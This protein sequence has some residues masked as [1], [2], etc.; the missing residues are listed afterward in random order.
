[1]AN[2]Q[3]ML[4][5][6]PRAVGRL[7]KAG[8][9][10]PSRGARNDYLFSFQ[11]IVLLRS[12]QALQAANVPPRRLLR[13]LRLLR[14]ALPGE[15]PLSGLRVK[16]IGDR[17]AVKEAGSHWDVE[18][19]QVLMDFEVATA[20][21]AVA[22]IVAATR[23][24]PDVSP[25]PVSAD[26]W[27]AQAESLEPSDPAAAMRAYRRALEIQPG[28]AGALTNLGALLCEAGDSQEALTLYE[29]AAEVAPDEP[30][31]HFNGAIALEDLGLHRAALRAYAHCLMLA[32]YMGDAH[33]NAARLCEQLGDQPGA[34]R[35]FNALRRMHKADGSEL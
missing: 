4:G 28:H 9:I 29:R 16:A 23:N 13:S 21:G 2:V 12:V 18:S 26:D 34:L 22:F 7:V 3:S 24:A 8:Y 15:L 25:D 35:H 10:A 6:T 17:V 27:V 32:P 33:Y 1:M 5:L 20:D 31:I 11:D 19:G 30:L 14:D